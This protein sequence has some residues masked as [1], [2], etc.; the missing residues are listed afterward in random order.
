VAL[1]H[2]TAFNM[3]VPDG[4]TWLVHE[5]PLSELDKIT[6]DGDP[7]GGVASPTSRQCVVEVHVSPVKY[8]MPDGVALPGAIERCFQEDPPLLVV[9]MLRRLPPL[10]SPIVASTSPSAMQDRRVVQVTRFNIS[11]PFGTATVPQLRPALFEVTAIALLIAVFTPTAMQKDLVGHETPTSLPT[12]FGN[13]GANDHEP[14]PL[15]VLSSAP[16]S[17]LP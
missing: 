9:M 14:P 5:P 10:G 12:P 6:P 2:E 7:S 4:T 11:S 3:V 8:G 13:A 1:P 16:R 15:R 17:P